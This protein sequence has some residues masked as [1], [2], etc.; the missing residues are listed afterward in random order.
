MELIQRIKECKTMSELDVLRLE[1]ITEGKSN[2]DTFQKLQ[3]E[4]I[5]KKNQ[6]K[7]I[8]LFEWEL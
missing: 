6:L 3:R 2:V 7:R 8:P 4:F 1:I 5:K